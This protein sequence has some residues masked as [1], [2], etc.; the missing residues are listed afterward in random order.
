MSSN[1]DRMRDLIHEAAAE[2]G[3]AR[4]AA[5]FQRAF[6]R[7]TGYTDTTT[8]AITDVLGMVERI[9]DEL[10]EHGDEI[11]KLSSRMDAAALRSDLDDLR[12]EVLDAT[13]PEAN[14]AA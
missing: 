13:A 1:A 6:D 7:I 14:D 3:T 2:P 12:L 10:S 4:L 9:W 8:R 5:D 11:V